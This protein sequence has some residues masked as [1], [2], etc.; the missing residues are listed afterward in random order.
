MAAVRPKP[1]TR[2]SKRPKLNTGG[3]ESNLQDLV[4]FQLPPRR[5]HFSGPRRSRKTT[6]SSLWTRERFVNSAYRFILKPSVTADYTV[7]FVD[8]DIYF[9]WGDI[10]QILV[11]YSSSSNVDEGNSTCP[12]CLGTPIAPRM[13]KCGHV[14]CYSCALHYL[15]TGEHGSW[16][17]CPICFDTI[18]E[19]SLK[20]VKWFYEAEADATGDS[21]LKL[22]L[23]ERPQ[24]TTLALP[25][26]DT[27]PS[28]LV[29]PHQVA[30]HFLPD[31]YTFARFMIPT[32]ES[33]RKDLE[34]EV[35]NLKI[36]RDDKLGYGDSIGASFVEG[37]IAKVR[38]LIE[39]AK[40]LDVP[41]M[42]EAI[43]AAKR[44][45]ERI[46]AQREM[47][48]NVAKFA[49][50]SIADP[51]P[52]D[53]SVQQEQGPPVMRES[54]AIPT[55][56]LKTRK[57]VNPPPPST[58][59]YYFY[60]AAS[61]S[62]TFLHPLDIRIL[63]SHFGSYANFPQNIEVKV[64][65][66]NE[67]TVDEDLRKRCRYLA[68][69]PEATDVTFVEVD[70]ECVVGKEAL[71]AFEGALKSR[72]ARR[73]EKER[74][75]D[76]AKI[77]AEEREKEKLAE[78]YW[79]LKYSATRTQTAMQREE[80]ELR[81][82]LRSENSSDETPV[83]Q[84]VSG[85][86]GQRSFASTLSGPATD[87]PDDLTPHGMMAY[88]ALS[89]RR[90]LIHTLMVVTPLAASRNRQP[91]SSP[92]DESRDWTMDVAWKELEEARN[93]A[94]GGGSRKKKA[95]KLILSL[96]GGGAP[97]SRRR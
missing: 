65:A 93:A 2:P 23:M 73:K 82:F 58:S 30:F 95:P 97:P 88:W 70:L 62:L 42:Q 22:R 37:A 40:Q 66:Q 69:L 10:A 21:T 28:D 92:G 25:Q 57:N 67:G 94:V 96:N 47:R 36:D 33:L 75:D 32:P 87:S 78:D 17:R 38:S 91:A 56:Q 43:T 77:R 6:V 85:A 7:H 63:L 54:S 18:S 68:H 86:W 41:A 12:I 9:Q 60:Q 74:K 26:S 79:V 3:D 24:I 20:P 83:Q 90:A 61:G 29:P 15:Q 64:E 59:T 8:P 50:F 14:Y 53:W 11:P 84:P 27:W 48:E 81:A 35:E 31:I 4:N 49:D 72:R 46:Q 51:R 13:T 71:V 55:K 45:V 52:T 16:H 34:D 44:G 19:S 39:E 5:Q 1:G 89:N 80:E 76:R